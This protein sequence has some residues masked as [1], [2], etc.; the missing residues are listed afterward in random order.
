MYDMATHDGMSRYST[1]AHEMGHMFDAHIGRDD[2]LTFKEADLI[3]EKCP[4]GIGN[5]KTIKTL[6]SSSDQFLEAMRK[7]KPL[8][9]RLLSDEDSLKEMRTGK[10]EN[11]T[12]GV[13]DAMDGFF[14][15]Q[16]KHI[17][18]WGHGETYYNRQYNN[19][20]KGF[21]NEKGLK[22]AFNELGF[23]ASNQTKVKTLMR[24]YETASELWA[25]GV[26]AIT[27][28]GDEL[29][30]FERYMPNTVDAIKSIIGG[31]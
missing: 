4:I 15:T 21:G 6:P 30:A 9:A 16:K 3:N 12:A 24:D 31:V 7:D 13:Q 25:N 28:G 1:L 11:A 10:W 8:L 2:S 22:D 14:G 18:P 19:K 17:L 27:C 5:Y 23:D 29:E 26:S 20:I